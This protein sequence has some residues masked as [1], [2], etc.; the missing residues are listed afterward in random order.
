MRWRD[1][2]LSRARFAVHV[3]SGTAVVADLHLGYGRV[4]RRGG[5]AV[6]MPSIAEE[7]EA[8]AGGL[9]EVGVGRVVV[10]GDLFEDGRYQRDE[11]ET[12]LLAWLAEQSVELA[13]V[14]GNHDRKL[15]GSRLAVVQ[16][17]AIGEWAVVHGDGELPAGPFVQG[18]E[19]PCLRVGAASAPCFLLGESRLVLPAYSANAAGGNVLGDGRWTGM[20]CVAIVEGRLLDFGDVSRAGQK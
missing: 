3:P 4:R 5:D 20:R 15:A 7:L 11:M 1:F 6:P 13:V 2:L 14:P 10:A 8:L 19:H 18:H 9:R 17:F 12:E 16:E